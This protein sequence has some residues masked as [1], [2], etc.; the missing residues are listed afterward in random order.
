MVGI[1]RRLQCVVIIVC[2]IDYCRESVKCCGKS[3]ELMY[4]RDKSEDASA[5]LSR[6]CRRAWNVFLLTL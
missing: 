4:N 6:N 5:R 2:A 3:P 1:L